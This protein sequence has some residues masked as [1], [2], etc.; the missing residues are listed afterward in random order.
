MEELVPLLLLARGRIVRLWPL[1]EL[2][3]KSSP[4]LLLPLLCIEQSTLLLL[5]S[6]W[7]PPLVLLSKLLP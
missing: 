4:K 1:L 3:L 5:L 7:S 2:L 6:K